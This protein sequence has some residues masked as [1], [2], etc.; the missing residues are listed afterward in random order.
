[1]LS[2]S[3]ALAKDVLRIGVTQYPS[4]LH[5]MIDSM[6]AK[7]YVNAMTQRPLTIHNPDWIPECMLCTELPTFENGRAEHVTLKDGTNTVKARYTIQ[8]NAKFCSNCGSSAVPK[9]STRRGLVCTN[10]KNLL[11]PGEKFCGKCG[12]PYVPK[13]NDRTGHVCTNCYNSLKASEKFCGK[14]GNPV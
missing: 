9:P 10:C 1:M 3:P 2:L 11:K 4:T 12:C 13:V 8:E 14:C 7:T 6:L 5:P